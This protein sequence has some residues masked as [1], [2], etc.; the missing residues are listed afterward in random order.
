[1]F[2]VIRFAQRGEPLAAVSVAQFQTAGCP[3]DIITADRHMRLDGADVHNSDHF[4][5]ERYAG[6]GLLNPFQK[7]AVRRGKFIR[8]RTEL[9]MGLGPGGG[10]WVCF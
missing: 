5:D 6:A 1:M 4:A 2:A 8:I 10:Q 7:S 9:P 3:D